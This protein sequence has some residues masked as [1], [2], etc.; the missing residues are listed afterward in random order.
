MGK[1]RHRRKNRS[2]SLALSHDEW[3]EFGNVARRYGGRSQY[4]AAF[5][6]QY[7]K[8]WGGQIEARSLR[9]SLEGR[10]TK[11]SRTLY[12]PFDDRQWWA[13]GTGC[14]ARGVTISEAVD[15]FCASEIAKAQSV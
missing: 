15:W 9:T 7:H 5:L 10:K 2:V 3:R 11:K 13:I 14:R 8:S 12:M 4:I 6:A 1:L